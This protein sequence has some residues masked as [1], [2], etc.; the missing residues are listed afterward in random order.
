VIFQPRLRCDVDWLR[1]IVTFHGTVG[2]GGE[3]LALYWHPEK[4]YDETGTYISYLSVAEDQYPYD[5]VKAVRL[6]GLEF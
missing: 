3:R 6:S 1:K 5:K 2:L 4:T